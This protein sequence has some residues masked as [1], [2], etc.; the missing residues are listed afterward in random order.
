MDF[1]LIRAKKIEFTRILI[2]KYQAFF[3]IFYI[4]ADTTIF[5]KNSKVVIILFFTP[6]PFETKFLDLSKDVSSFECSFHFFRGPHLRMRAIGRKMAADKAETLRARRKLNELVNS[7]GP[8]NKE[9]VVYYTDSFFLFDSI[10]DLS[11][12]FHIQTQLQLW[13]L[14]KNGP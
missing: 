13:T 12:R 4:I 6:G 2:S 1:F 7:Q 14:I 8:S 3:Y 9:K 5:L 10:Q 11:F